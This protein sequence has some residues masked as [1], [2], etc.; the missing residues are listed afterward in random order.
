[1]SEPVPL[2]P[3]TAT[4]ISESARSALAGVRASARSKAAS[5]GGGAGGAEPSS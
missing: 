2:T 5:I 3:T 4:V 1:M